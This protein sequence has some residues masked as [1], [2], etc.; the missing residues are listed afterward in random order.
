MSPLA[1]APALLQASCAMRT[2][3]FTGTRVHARTQRVVG[4]VGSRGL[5]V[6]VLH[7]G[8]IPPLGLGS[9]ECVRS[10]FH[11]TGSACACSILCSH[12]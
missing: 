3:A 10:D 8:P 7:G 9:S 6:R 4:R 12:V 11:A 5:Q 1:P 2:Q